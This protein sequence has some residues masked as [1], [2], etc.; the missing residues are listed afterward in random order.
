[1]PPKVRPCHQYISPEVVLLKPFNRPLFQISKIGP[2]G[3]LICHDYSLDSASDTF[4]LL[5]PCPE[6]FQAQPAWRL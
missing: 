5:E 3:L 2:F 4:D 6:T 1:M